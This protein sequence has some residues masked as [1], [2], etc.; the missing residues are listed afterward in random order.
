SGT[1]HNVIPDRATLLLTV[2]SYADSTRRH[3]LTEIERVARHVALDHGAG[4][5]PDVIVTDERSRAAYNDPI[6]T[7]TLTGSFRALLGP[8]RVVPK[9]PSLGGED[10]GEFSRA[11]GFPG[12]MWKLGT[13]PPATLR[14]QG[15]TGVPGL[16]S[17]RFA[18][19][20]RR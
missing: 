18:P 2:R 10:F 14:K 12:V 1:R 6:W 7:E 8:T 16:H 5:P 15:V 13:T 19:A 4:R 3:L 11:L 17:D 9:P 20:H